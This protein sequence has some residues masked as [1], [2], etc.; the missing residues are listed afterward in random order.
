[1]LEAI[2]RLNRQAQSVC[3]TAAA[4]N[5]DCLTEEYSGAETIQL[6][7]SI[8]ASHQD[9]VLKVAFSVGDPFA[10]LLRD[11]HTPFQAALGAGGPP[12]PTSPPIR[13]PWQISAGDAYGHGDYLPP[14]TPNASPPA[15]GAERLE[16][17]DF[18]KRAFFGQ[19]QIWPSP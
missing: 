7:V 4:I 15:M 11:D 19:P 9:V 13:F 1:M 3:L 12:T 17:P 2:T 16:P 6:S 8:L 18:M 10:E 5:R 14:A